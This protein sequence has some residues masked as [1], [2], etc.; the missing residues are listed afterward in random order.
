MQAENVKQAGKQEMLSKQADMQAG[1]VK[2]AGMLGR[3]RIMQASRQVR[4]NTGHIHK[5]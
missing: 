2:Q 5:R 1:N 3:Q 4:R